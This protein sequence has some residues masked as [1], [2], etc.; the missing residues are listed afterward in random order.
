LNDKIT[1]VP[2][3]KQEIFQT[4]LVEIREKLFIKNFL[5]EMIEQKSM[6]IEETKLYQQFMN[7]PEDQRSFR[8][9]LKEMALLIIDIY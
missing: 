5:T 1:R 2:D 3:S 6:K 4:T 7:Q 9:I 8:K